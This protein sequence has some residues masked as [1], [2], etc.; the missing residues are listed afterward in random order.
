MNKVVE[1]LTGVGFLIGIYLFLRNGND[2]VKI[3]ETIGKNSIAGI[4]TLQGR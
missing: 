1:I 2:T 3:I 4:K